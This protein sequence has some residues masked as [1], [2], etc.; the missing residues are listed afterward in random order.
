MLELFYYQFV[1][2]VAHLS[3]LW[4]LMN[5]IC[6]WLGVITHFQ[7]VPSFEDMKYGDRTQPAFN[8]NWIMLRCFVLLSLFVWNSSQ[9]KANCRQ[10]ST[11]NSLSV[12][13]ANAP[14]LLRMLCSC[15]ANGKMVRCETK[16]ISRNKIKISLD[17]IYP[18]NKRRTHSIL[19]QIQ[20][21]SL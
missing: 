1:N 18:S 11:W 3:P 20:L 19:H 4:L 8:S 13:F 5:Q 15:H 21:I 12:F 10:K 2:R 9:M 14:W 16:I 6:R 7:R 17:D